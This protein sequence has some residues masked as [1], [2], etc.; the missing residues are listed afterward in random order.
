MIFIFADR[1]LYAKNT[2]VVQHCIL[3]G[4][5]NISSTDIAIIAT[6]HHYLDLRIV[7]FPVWNENNEVYVTQL[8]IVS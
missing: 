2:S 7:H 3:S 6:A 1:T 4:L 5:Y 8:S